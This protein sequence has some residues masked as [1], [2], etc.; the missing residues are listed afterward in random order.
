MMLADLDAR[1]I[2][3][4][5]LEGDS[6]REL[7]G[8]YGWNRGK[9]SLAV[10][11]KTPDGLGIVHALVRRGDVVLENM[12]P[13]V[14]ERLGIDYARLSALNP[15][16]VY[17]SVTGFG[18]GGPYGSRPAFDPLLQAM[19]GVMELQGFGG[20]PQ[21]L[22]IPS[23]DYYAAALA[24]Q[25][26]LAALYVRERTGRGQRVETSLLQGVL[27]MQ[28]GNVAEF[29]GKRVIYRENAT[30]RLYRGSDGGW[31]FLACGNQSFWEKL[32]RAIERPELAQ[33]PRFGS[34]LA[35]RDSGHLLAPMLEETFASRPRSDWLR[36]LEEHDIPCAAVRDL[37]D[38][39][40]DPA[41]AH[42]EM[43]VEY[44]HPELGSLA[45]MGLPMRFSETQGRPGVRPPLLGEHTR[46]ILG[47]LGY[48]APS[49][50]DLAARGV[51][52]LPA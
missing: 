39:L 20:D 38:F 1:V 46:E 29:P 33:D 48:A 13:G 18:S 4:E 52:R 24:T 44:G 7:P 42:L 8:F 2:K 10:D 31:F 22:R 35:R 41:V 40:A 30:Y 50:E 16:L 45:L 34:F 49:V 9:R 25:G 21:Y 51:V 37:H 36:I 23:T 3:V 17:C 47:E 14:T 32:C 19:A 11:L 5:S 28:S 43:V 12:R 15:R 27:A 6:F 26:I